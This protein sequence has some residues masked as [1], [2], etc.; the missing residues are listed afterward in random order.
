MSLCDRCKNKE[1]ALTKNNNEK[2]CSCRYK[3]NQHCDNIV[4]FAQ[5]KICKECSFE[6][7]ICE[8]CGKPIKKSV[9]DLLKDFF[10]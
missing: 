8:I 4:S 10:R 9:L 5:A 3:K 1:T 7:N 2:R 6:K